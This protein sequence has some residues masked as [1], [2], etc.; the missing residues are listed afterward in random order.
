MDLW[1]VFERDH[2][3]TLAIEEPKLGNRRASIIQQALLKGRV[4]PCPGHYA[5]SVSGT[6]L[7]LKGIDDGIQRCRVDEPFLDQQRFHCLHAQAE[8]GRHVLVLVLVIVLVIVQKS[9]RPVR[10]LR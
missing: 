8:V 2:I 3:F 1:S 5:R 7:G 6:D 9:A 10:R 4:N